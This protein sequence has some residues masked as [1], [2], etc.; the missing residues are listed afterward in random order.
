SLH[1]LTSGEEAWVREGGRLV[2]AFDSS[3]GP[4]AATE[5]HGRQ[6]VRKVFPIW[7][8]VAHLVPPVVRGL[9]VQP[10]AGLHAVFL[11]GDSALALRQALGAGELILLAT[12]EVL[13]NR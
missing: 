11:A 3:Y 4:A 10:N 2:I 5:L 6:P 7:P 12:P 13:E 8:G 9:E 1:F